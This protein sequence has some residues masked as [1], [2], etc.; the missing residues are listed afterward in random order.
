MFVYLDNI[1]IFFSKTLE[2]H[3]SHVRAVLQRL[4]EN[5]LYVKAEKC[6][7]HSR[8]VSF[9][10]Y[11]LA[12]GQVK[13]DP[14]KVKAVTEWLAPTTRKLLQRFLGFANFY[15]RFIHNYSSVAAPLTHLTS[16]KLPFRWTSEPEAAFNKLKTFV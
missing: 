9:L 14:A 12:G 16:T 13:T 3:R 4:L 6:E 15:R 2:E 7:F 11:V 10:G 8:T 5:K 1:L